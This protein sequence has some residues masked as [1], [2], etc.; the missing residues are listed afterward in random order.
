VTRKV[1]PVAVWGDRVPGV[2]SD[3]H[4][5]NPG[6]PDHDGQDIMFPA[7]DGDPAYSKETRRN[8]SPRWYMPDGRRALAAED[9]KAARV[10]LRDNGW[11][12]Y[13]KHS[14]GHTTVYRHLEMPLVAVGSVAMAGQPIGVIGPSDDIAAKP[15]IHPLK[16]L[17]FE[18]RTKAGA[19]LDPAPY[20]LDAEFIS[21]DGRPF[22]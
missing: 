5:R 9:G 8:R 17:H 15:G 14:R 2:S 3:A 16:H 21:E 1:Y 7:V 4:W 22:V 6:R 19:P 20:L 13:L 11:A 18:V 12:V 10:E